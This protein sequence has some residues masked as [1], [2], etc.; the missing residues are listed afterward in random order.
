MLIVPLMDVFH[1]T[2]FLHCLAEVKERA[3]A[4]DTCLRHRR[5][6]TTPFFGVSTPLETS[7]DVLQKQ[8]RDEYGTQ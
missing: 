3:D 2:G 4:I 5:G 8:K 6:L 1:H 7:M